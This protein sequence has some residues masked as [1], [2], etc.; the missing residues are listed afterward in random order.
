MKLSDAFFKQL[1]RVPIH[2]KSYLKTALVVLVVGTLMGSCIQ[3]C[4]AWHRWDNEHQRTNPDTLMRKKA[5]DLVEA[6][7]GQL[8]YAFDRWEYA[9][10]S[11]HPLLGHP[12]WFSCRANDQSAFTMRTTNNLTGE[13]AFYRVCCRMEN[14]QPDC[15]VRK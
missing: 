1:E 5:F 7:S 8:P 14:G 15:L 4:R 11:Q 12:E 9:T 10:Q 6:D 2:V 13:P 3:G